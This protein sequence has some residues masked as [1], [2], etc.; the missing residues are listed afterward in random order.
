MGTTN[1]GHVVA[2]LKGLTINDNGFFKLPAGDDDS[3]S[4]TPAEGTLRFNTA[5]GRKEVYRGNRWKSRGV[6]GSRNFVY[7]S[8]T[9]PTPASDTGLQLHLDA[10]DTDSY[11]G[12]GTTWTDLSGN[13]N[14]FKISASAWR[15]SYMDFRGNHGIAKKL[16]QTDL[17]LPKNTTFVMITRPFNSTS[18][19]RTCTRAWAGDHHPMGQSGAWNMG[20]YD[21]NGSAFIS[22]G[23]EQNHTPGYD[24]Q[25]FELWVV[26]WQAGGTNTVNFNINGAYVGQINNTN[27]DMDYGIGVLGGWS[28]NRDNPASASQYWGDI[29]LFQA[30]GY[31]FSDSE[32][33]DTF[34]TM[35][36][37]LG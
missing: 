19:W 18:T 28:S 27:A 20:V 16:S 36:G 31:R 9:L 7:R 23:F 5:G 2:S 25:K 34:Q 24:E 14:H 1:G 10:E 26:R 12:T 6:K 3:R 33:R 22:A 29:R 8:F 32:V 35:K 11:P 30:Y 15:K 37:R 13:G 21:N 17:S 4:D